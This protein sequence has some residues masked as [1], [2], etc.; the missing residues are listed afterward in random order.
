MVSIY[1]TLNRI[2]RKEEDNSTMKENKSW[3]SNIIL[4]HASSY[5]PKMK[6]IVL[7][8]PSFFCL[9]SSCFSRASCWVIFC[10][11]NSNSMFVSFSWLSSAS[12][13]TKDLYLGLRGDRRVRQITLHIYIYIQENQE[14]AHKFI[15]IDLLWREM[16]CLVCHEYY[17]NYNWAC[18]HYY[19]LQINSCRLQL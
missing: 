3:S 17:Y 10:L 11:S 4:L 7:I 13:R 19:S 12:C 9:K 15:L 8:P 6:G 14:L 18:P 2:E 1:W 16:R 5:I